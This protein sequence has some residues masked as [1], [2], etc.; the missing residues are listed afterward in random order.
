M[1]SALAA[2]LVIVLAGNLVFT[3]YTLGGMSLLTLFTFLGAVATTLLIFSLARRGKKVHVVT[4]LLG[5]IAINALAGA[6]TGLLTFV[7]DDAQLRTI[8]FWT[9]GSLGGASWISVIILSITTSLTLYFILP[10]FKSFNALSLGEEE[11]AYLGINTEELKRK[12]ILFTALSIGASVAFCGMIGF[13]GLVVPHIL[14]LVVGSDHR[15]LL[16]ASALLGALLLCWADNLSRTL[17]A[18]AELPIGIIT[19]ICGA[20]VFL[21]LLVQR[22]KVMS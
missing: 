14:R 22:K 11:A 3:S 2:A 8:T 1:G 12:V 18:P 16:P 15:S 13:V 21:F 17:I 4:L 6:G 20:P 7:A 19:A 5:G 10:L 9:L